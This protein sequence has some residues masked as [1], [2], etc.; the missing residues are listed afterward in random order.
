MLSFLEKKPG[1]PVSIN[2]SSIT[3][4]CL[5]FYTINGIDNKSFNEVIKSAGVSKGSIYRLY[6]SEDSLQKEVLDEYFHNNMK[7]RLDYMS[8][9]TIK[10]FIM[11]VTSALITDKT[12]PC[13]F[14]RSRVEKYKLGPKTRQY[15]DLIEEKIKVSFKSLIKLHFKKKNVK[16]SNLYVE[17][18][19]NFYI[20]NLNTLHL[21]KL[22]NAPHKLIL[23]F[24]KTILKQ[25]T[26]N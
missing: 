8:K 15:I 14:W 26:K 23:N 10:E 17:E 25:L 16:V 13:I 1:R 12:K 9:V 3:K 22:N 18:L 21:L 20:N 19:T 4:K 11:D 6:G 7:E 5:D 2:K 24:S